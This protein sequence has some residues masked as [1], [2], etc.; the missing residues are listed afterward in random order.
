MMKQNGSSFTFVNSNTCWHH[1]SQKFSVHTNAYS[2]V[3]FRE[4]CFT[5]ET[6]SWPVGDQWCQAHP[7]CR[8]CSTN[9]VVCFSSPL[10]VVHHFHVDSSQ[11]RNPGEGPELKK[12]ISITESSDLIKSN[13]TKL[14]YY[15]LLYDNVVCVKSCEWVIW[16]LRR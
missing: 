15:K 9:N 4:N 13:V 3:Q 6:G 16:I 12:L 11:Q 2:P 7:V 8:W 1:S 10:Q 14:S 5:V